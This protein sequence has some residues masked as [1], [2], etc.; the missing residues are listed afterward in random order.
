MSADEAIFPLPH[1]LSEVPIGQLI[2][3]THMDYHMPLGTVLPIV[4]RQSFRIAGYVHISLWMCVYAV[5]RGCYQ[6]SKPS[7]PAARQW[8]R[9]ASPS[10]KPAMYQ[11]NNTQHDCG[12]CSFHEDLLHG[13]WPAQLHSI[14]S[15]SSRSLLPIAMRG[16]QEVMKRL[17]EADLPAET[18]RMQASSSLW[19]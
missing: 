9:R 4:A 16:V 10:S 7:E 1:L 15:S 19:C 18:R 12:T 6:S 2:R 14:C 5:N 3:S 8:E 17:R 13:S 11:H